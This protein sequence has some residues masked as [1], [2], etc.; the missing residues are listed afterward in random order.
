[1]PYGVQHLHSTGLNSPLIGL[2]PS[3]TRVN[4]DSRHGWLETVGRVTPRQAVVCTR[5]VLIREFNNSYLRKVTFILFVQ[6]ALV[7]SFIVEKYLKKL[8]SER[9]KGSKHLVC[10]DVIWGAGKELGE[11]A[12]HCWQD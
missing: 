7:V 10:A 8:L 3:P 12:N 4:R 9:S 1:M 5:F 11:L 2:E 6:W